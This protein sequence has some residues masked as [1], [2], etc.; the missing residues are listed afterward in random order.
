MLFRDD[1]LFGDTPKVAGEV[2]LTVL[3][4]PSQICSFVARS[5]SIFK[6]RLRIFVIFIPQLTKIRRK[7]FTDYQLSFLI[8][9]CERTIAFTIL[10]QQTKA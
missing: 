1:V 3:I 5:K 4:L 10:C 6:Q 7:R 9:Q 8:L 2:A